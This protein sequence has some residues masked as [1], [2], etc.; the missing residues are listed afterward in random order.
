M[1]SITNP[2]MY[3]IAFDFYEAD[4]VEKNQKEAGNNL[5]KPIRQ[6]Y[7]DR[8][9][10]CEVDQWRFSIVITERLDIDGKQLYHELVQVFKETGLFNQ[11]GRFKDPQLFEWTVSE[12]TAD[13][14]KITSGHSSEALQLLRR[15]KRNILL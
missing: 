5:F 14:P 11:D 8:L 6:K 1:T 4:V 15:Y 10:E 3:A 9:L 7:G 13:G 2:K 12:Q